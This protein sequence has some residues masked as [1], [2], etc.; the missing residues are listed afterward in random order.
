MSE[1]V[2]NAVRDAVQK[3]QDQDAFIGRGLASLEEARRTGTF[4]EADVVVGQL[5]EKLA[6]ARARAAKKR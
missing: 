1:F 4:I 2:E 5:Q 3:R 6:A